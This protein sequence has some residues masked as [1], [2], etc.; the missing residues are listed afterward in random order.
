MKDTIH[1]DK[2]AI[3]ILRELFLTSAIGEVKKE[4]GIIQLCL[5]FV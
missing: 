1:R 3:L 4:T 5:S 2:G